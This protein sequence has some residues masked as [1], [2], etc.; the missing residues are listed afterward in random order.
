MRVL[1]KHEPAMSNHCVLCGNGLDRQRQDIVIDVGRDLELPGH[2]LDGRLFVCQG[3]V[4]D[5]ARA[6]GLMTATDV[7]ETQAYLRKYRNDVERVHEEVAVHLDNARRAFTELPSP[8][9]LDH[10]T[11]PQTVLVAEENAALTR[12]NNESWVHVDDDSPPF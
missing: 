9:N 10:L 7:T 11:V 6:T 5:I 3:C 8:P 1:E 12:L 4:F 2:Q